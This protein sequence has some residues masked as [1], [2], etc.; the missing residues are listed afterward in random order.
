VF[1][2][3]P[4][5]LNTSLALRQAIWRK[6]D[7]AWHVCG[8]PDTLYV[9]HGSDFTS[10]H[11]SQVAA[12]LRIEL[13]Y[14]AVARPQGRG[15]VERLFG[16][17]N[18]ELLP[19]LPGHLA[20]GR[21]A[22]PPRLSLPELDSAVGGYIT[23]TYHVR[24]HRETGTPPVAAWAGEGWL[25]RMPASLEDLDLLLVMVATPRMVHRDGI[26]FQGL[27]YLSPTLAAYVR[28]PVTIRYDPRDITEIR[29]FHRN[30]FLCRAISPEHA[31]ETITLKDLQA[32]RAAHRRALREQI[33]QRLTAITDYLPGHPQ[34]HAMPA[35]AA[36]PRRAP[37][38]RLRTYR[39]DTRE[40]PLA[41]PAG[42][43]LHHHQRTPPV[44][45]I[46]PRRPAPPLHRPVLRPGRSRQDAVSPPL[47]PLGPRRTVPAQ[48]GTTPRHRRENLRRPGRRPH[49]VLHPNRRRHPA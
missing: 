34:G 6:T 15:K 14:S 8:I 33:S 13:V 1:L 11:L 29:V 17:L 27:R 25:P 37:A 46:R 22:T 3:A 45:G 44:P 12:D 4:S 5:A 30:R 40:H 49:R 41:C 28:E 9:D 36:A 19:E 16:T 23:G 20:G 39:E 31:G 48:L 18:T 26:H 7:P 21:P 35:P 32:A 24:P 38:S 2:S 47:R 43:S 42:G 10:T